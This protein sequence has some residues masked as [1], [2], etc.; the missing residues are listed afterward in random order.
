MRHANLPFHLYLNVSNEYLGPNMPKGVTPCMWHASYCR[1]GQALMCHVL[2]ESGA[3][4]SGLPIHALSS[5]L[6]FSRTYN[7]LMP[8]AAMGNHLEIVMIDLLEGKRTHIMQPFKSSG[9]HTGLIFDWSDGYSRYPQEHKPLSLIQTDLGQLA[10]LP[11]NYILLED[12]HFV[13]EDAKDNLKYYK[14]GETVYWG[15]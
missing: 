7:Q 1:S 4:W 14:R 13:S 11:N 8:W 10:L 6:D 12:K 2:L 9:T 15:E 5:T 3:H